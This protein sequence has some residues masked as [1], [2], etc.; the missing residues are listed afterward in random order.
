MVSALESPLIVSVIVLSYKALSLL[1]VFKRFLSAIALRLLR[2]VMR[3]FLVVSQISTGLFTIKPS[4]LIY[5]IDGDFPPG[6]F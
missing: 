2:L 3:S 1:T 5:Y 4:N 6:Y